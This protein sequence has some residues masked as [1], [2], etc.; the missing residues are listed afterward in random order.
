MNIAKNLGAYIGA[1]LNDNASNLPFGTQLSV[2]QDRLAYAASIRS[3]ASA[4]PSTGDIEKTGAANY[5][6]LLN[7][8]DILA[9]NRGC[10]TGITPTI[11]GSPHESAFY[12]R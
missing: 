11:W 7:T 4:T 2:D 9:D 6:H 10:G 3:R 5:K 8:I 1:L 12:V